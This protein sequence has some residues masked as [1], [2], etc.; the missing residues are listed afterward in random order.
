VAHRRLPAQSGARAALLHTHN[1]NKQANGKKSKK[2]PKIY[3]SLV[4]LGQE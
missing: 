2:G 1:Q 3:G 4:P